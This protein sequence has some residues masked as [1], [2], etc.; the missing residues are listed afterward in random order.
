[1]GR[2][3]TVGTVLR[4]LTVIGMLLAYPLGAVSFNAGGGYAVHVLS[5]QDQLV[6]QQ[7]HEYGVTADVS[8]SHTLSVGGGI[9]WRRAAPVLLPDSS[10]LRGYTS[11]GIR[12]YLEHI[13]VEGSLLCIGY[14]PFLSA[15]YAA[16]EHIEHVFIY[17][18]GGVAPFIE[19]PIP[20]LEL[21][22]LRIKFPVSLMIKRDVPL[23]MHAGVNAALRVSVGKKE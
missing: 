6:F 13:V 1:M 19:L 8:L 21:V 17:L 15:Q 16:Y 14:S 12:G 23:H 11:S 2:D 20:L 9:S 10:V 22:S 5:L 3:K 7:G 18:Q 4:V